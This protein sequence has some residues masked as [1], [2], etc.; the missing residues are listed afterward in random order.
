MMAKLHLQCLCTAVILAATL[1]EV[2]GDDVCPTSVVQTYVEETLKDLAASNAA[3]DLL[4]RKSSEDGEIDET[5]A[6]LVSELENEE[7]DEEVA[8]SSEAESDGIVRLLDFTKAKLVVNNLG[9]QGPEKKLP[10]GDDAPEEMRFA[11]LVQGGALE[12]VVTTEPGYKAF[13]S[14]KN[15]ILSGNGQINALSGTEARLKFTFVERGTNK[16]HVMP[17]F[18]ITFS[19][20]DERHKGKE[21]EMI[22]VDGF[23]KYYT[24]DDLK[25]IEEDGQNPIF[26]SSD[27]GDYDDNEFSPDSPSPPQLS[28]AVTYL[29]R[30]KASFDAVFSITGQAKKGR[31]VL[32]SGISQLVFCQEES[33]YLNFSHAE[34]VQSN[35]GGKGPDSGPAE[36]R[37][38]HIGTYRGETLDLVVTTKD[39]YGYKP[40]NVTQNGL[41]G[42]FGLINLWSGNT[43]KNSEAIATFSIVKQGTNE[44][45]KL[46]QFALVVFDFDSGNHEQQVEYIE[47]RPNGVG[48]EGGNGYSSYIVTQTTEVAVQDVGN[49]GRKR[50][51]ATKH[52][53]EADNPTSA[54]NMA[55]EVADKSVVF[56]FR[57]TGSFS[58]LL[59]ITPTGFDTGRNFMFSGQ[60]MYLMCD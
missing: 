42:E 4:Q 7:S 24:N 15:G 34:V 38:S 2:C 22:Q 16:P 51:V 41:L 58:M 45:V 37:Y 56:T 53:T 19:D 55:R 50:F 31:N 1:A 26:E 14:S 3:V 52:G 35:L 18:Y 40:Y 33:T 59:G 43:Q 46:E 27:F 48:F 10:N 54:Q 29:F 21:Q 13:N 17:K 57:K 11:N 47:I 25:V 30:N 9:G 44:A 12:L 32:F 28:H 6:A 20:L 8:T 49:D 60:D 36:L 23:E 39:S 5:V